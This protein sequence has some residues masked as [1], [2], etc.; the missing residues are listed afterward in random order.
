[1]VEFAI[2]LPVALLV[3][4]GIIVGSFLFF[5]SEAVTNGARGGARW[6]TIE[7]NLWAV[8]GSTHCESGQP[9]WIANA[10]QKSANILPVNT[11]H[12]CANG[13]S[14]TEL[15]QTPTDPSK[16][17]IVVDATPSLAAPTCVTVSV[18]YKT[19]PL[20]IPFVSTITL[21]GYSSSPIPASSSSTTTT[22][23]GI[24]CPAPGSPP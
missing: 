11:A 5:Q 16:A 9:D 7:S 20:A 22:S 24:S 23:T 8:S 4:L 14:T 21:R 19:T 12:L 1:M 15:V 17:N 3:I 18:T 13:A 2:I 6:A 10:V